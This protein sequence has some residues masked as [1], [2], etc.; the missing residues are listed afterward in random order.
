MKQEYLK[1]Y[2][3]IRPRIKFETFFKFRLMTKEQ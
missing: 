2:L 3:I 1:L